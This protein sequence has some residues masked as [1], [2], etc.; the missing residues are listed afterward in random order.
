MSSRKTIWD[1]FKD[2]EYAYGYFEEFLNTYVAT[3]IKVLREQRKLKQEEV[4][5][6]AGMAQERVC[7]MENVN[8]SS[9]TVNTLRKLA[10]ALGVRLKV[11]FETFSSGI[12]ESRDFKIESLRRDSLQDELDE[13]FNPNASQ[14][15][16][17]NRIIQEIYSLS[18]NS[19][20]G[21][22]SSDFNFIKLASK[23]FHTQLAE[24]SD[25]TTDDQSSESVMAFPSIRSQSARKSVG[26]RL[27]H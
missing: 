24:D 26:D 3:Q 14:D 6:L 15:K 10:K 9:W 16:P 20:G 17:Q 27:L 18:I 11:S 22:Q 23:N 8:Y 21:K 25:E 5:E 1:E 19:N 13:R 7:L 4:G 12:Q 2:P